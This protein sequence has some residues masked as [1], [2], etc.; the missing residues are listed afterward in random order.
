M[1]HRTREDH[2]FFDVNKVSF[3]LALRTTIDRPGVCNFVSMALFLLSFTKFTIHP[4]DTCELI[5]YII[6]NN[7]IR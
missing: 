5:G 3:V 7:H 1:Y 6:E 4:E 2:K